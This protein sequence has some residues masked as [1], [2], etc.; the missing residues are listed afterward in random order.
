[1]SS[2]NSFLSSFNIHNNNSNTN[3]FEHK[4]DV[5]CFECLPFSLR[6]WKGTN[7]RALPDG[8]VDQAP[9]AKLWEFWRLVRAEKEGVYYLRSWRDT[10]LAATDDGKI[11]QSDDKCPQAEWIITHNKGRFMIRSTHNTHLRAYDD[12]KMIDLA[13]HFRL[14][15]EWTIHVDSTSAAWGF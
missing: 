5:T 3:M 2:L 15:E 9:H 13:P 1:M 4:L 11:Y 6:S 7:L 12:G 8:D 14:W 10:Y